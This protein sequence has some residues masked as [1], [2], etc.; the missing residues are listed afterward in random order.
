[1][2]NRGLNIVDIILMVAMVGVLI[3]IS[4]FHTNS[5]PVIAVS[6]Y[7]YGEIASEMNKYEHIEAI[8]NLG[9]TPDGKTIFSYRWVN[10]GVFTIVGVSREDNRLRE[11][12]DISV[13]RR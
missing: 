3:F 2:R 8:A 11:D 6:P 12:L 9:V 5:N 7:S 1:M 10:Y 13:V 4:L